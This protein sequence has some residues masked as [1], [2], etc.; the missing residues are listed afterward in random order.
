V[1]LDKG[2]GVSG[3]IELEYRYPGPAAEEP[4]P[5]P[6]LSGGPYRYFTE[7]YH[8]DTTVATPFGDIEVILYRS[9]RENANLDGEVD[10]YWMDYFA[11]EIGWIGR[12]YNRADGHYAWRPGYPKL[13]VLHIRAIRAPAWSSLTT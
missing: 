4:W 2:L 7:L 10:V 12:E 3:L 6:D 9:Y 11:E 1:K 13:D 5:L 8:P